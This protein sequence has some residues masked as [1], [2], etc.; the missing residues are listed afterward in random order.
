MNKEQQKQMHIITEHSV[1]L[2]N[3]T[4]DKL[5]LKTSKNSL[6]DGKCLNAVQWPE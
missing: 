3:T 6:S 4:K 2:P 5:T 1:S